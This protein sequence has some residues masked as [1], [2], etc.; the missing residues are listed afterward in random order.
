M[1]RFALSV[2]GVT[3]NLFF[4]VCQKCHSL[5]RGKQNVESSQKHGR[6]PRSLYT[7]GHTAQKHIGTRVALSQERMKLH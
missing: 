2:D 1:F 5:Q 7:M 3:R 6:K 4:E